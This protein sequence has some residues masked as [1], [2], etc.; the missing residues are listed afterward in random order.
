MADAV[1]GLACGLP[2]LARHLVLVWLTLVVVLLLRPLLRR[3][4]GVQASAAAWGAVPAAALGGTLPLPGAW[5][6][7][8][9]SVMH[10]VGSALTSPASG[11]AATGAADLSFV[12]TSTLAAVLVAL[13]LAGLLLTAAGLGWRQ[14]RAA[15]LLQR[16]AQG[17]WRAPAGSSPALVGARQPRLALPRDFEA[18]FDAA[19][20]AAILAHEAMHLRRRDNL[21]ALLACTLA[22]LQWFNPWAWWALRR[23]RGDQELACDA[24]V[25]SSH[26]AVEPASYLRALLKSDKLTAPLTATATSWRGTHP[27]VERITLLTRRRVSN[28]RRHF[29]RTV[30]AVLALSALA[31]G[32]ATQGAPDAKSPLPDSVM[33]HMTLDVDGTRVA[34]PR[35]FG[36]LGQALSMRWQSDAGATSASALEVGVI[37]TVTERG[38]LRFEARLS[39]GDPLRTLATP[40]LVSAEGDTARFEVGPSGGGKAVTVTLSGRRTAAPVKS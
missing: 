10:W 6:E 4:L 38:Q 27:L 25:L 1:L 26:P 3:S 19:E 14:R 36:K 18:R 2:D 22:T 30:A 37:T 5:P 35:L 20:Q 23:F 9:P 24:A 7:L 34:T 32:H 16:D 29:G 39:G 33:L 11:G 8:A 13:W 40:T 28:T 31:A 12:P 21:W 15:G 17:L